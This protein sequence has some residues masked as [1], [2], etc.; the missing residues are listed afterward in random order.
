MPER[1]SEEALWFAFRDEQLLVLDGDPVRVPDSSTF[2]ELGLE[3]AFRWEIGTLNGARCWAVEIDSD[4]GTPD[5]MVLRDLRSLFAGIDEGFFK[6]AGKA[7]QVVGW[8]TTHRF[9]GRDGTE[10][11]PVAGEMAKRCPR[12]GMIYYPRLS[13]AIIVLIR[14]GDHVLLARSPGFPP[15]IYSV[16]AGFVEPGEAIEEAIKREVREEAGIEVENIRYFG[17]QPWPFPN[18]L[19]IG[20]T[21]EYAGG[22][23]RIDPTEVEDAGWYTPDRMPPL[24]PRFSIARSMIED[25]LDRHGS[26]PEGR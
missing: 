14:N 13:P 10:T 4:G 25:F 8:H 26:N 19:M 24:P 2:E 22:E 7:K 1:G 21:A 12:C 11:G 5:G 23:L 17:S 9:C 6:M 3:A 16:L 20:F 15:G 18:S